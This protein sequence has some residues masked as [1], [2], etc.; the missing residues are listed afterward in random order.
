MVYDEFE[1]ILPWFFKSQGEHEKLLDPVGELHEVVAFEERCHAPVGLVCSA[2]NSETES[3]REPRGSQVC[4]TYRA[5]NIPFD[6]TRSVA[7]TSHTAIGWTL[8]VCQIRKDGPLTIPMLP[9]NEK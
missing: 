7:A 4:V 9:K 2:E 1:E 8:R 3:I 6:T 5:S